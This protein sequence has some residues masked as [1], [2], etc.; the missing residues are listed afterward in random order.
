MTSVEVL[1][2][3]AVEQ[4]SRHLGD[5]ETGSTITRL[6]TAANLPQPEPAD[7]T[8][9]R[10]IY[11]ALDAEQ[12]RTRSGACVIDLIQRVMSPQKWTNAE[13]YSSFRAE[14]NQTLAFNGLAVGRDGRVS[15]R[16]VATTHDEA[17]SETARRLYRAMVDRGGHAEVFK[18]CTEQ[19]VAEDCFFAVLEA[20]KGTA[21]RIRE[22]TGL[23]LD[24]HTLVDA[25]FLGGSPALALNSLRTDTERNEQ[26]GIANL[27]KGCFSAFRN[28]TAHEPH[29]RWH[30]SEADTLDLLSTLSLI[31][32]RLDTA[33][34]LHS[35]PPA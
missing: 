11:A 16:A 22:M 9:W 25:A 7:G 4:I 32:R 30:I 19:L 2:D 1:P 29:V 26:R 34:V 14:L 20:T 27:M 5:V 35:Q 28:P 21:E 18:Y 33:V 10:R 6:L 17:A 23:D 12:R 24:G 15:R 31:H 8:K 13:A 3:A